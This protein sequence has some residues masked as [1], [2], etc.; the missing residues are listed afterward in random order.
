M[1]TKDTIEKVR[2]V[3]RVEEVVGDV[4]RLKRRG[5]NMMGLCPFHNEKTPSFVVSPAKGIYK[6]F[7]CG[8]S[9]D[10]I[11]FVI[12][13]EKLTYP[14]A[15]RFLANRY[16]IEIEEIKVSE[17]QK[18]EQSLRESLYIAL[19]F[20]QEWFAKQMWETED[21]KAIA[22]SY[23]KERGFIDETIRQFG[24]GYSATTSDGFLKDA[25]KQAFSRE[26]LKAAGLVGEKDG[27]WYDFFRERVMFPIHNVMG[28]VIGFGGRI[29]VSNPKVGK[30]VN[31]PETEVYNKSKSLYG[32]FQAK[33][34]IRRLDNALLVEGYTDV[35]SFHQAGI[36]NAVASSGTSLT[37]EQVK[38]IKRFTE[39]VTII[40]DGDAAG[41]KAAIRGL[42]I[43]L[44]EGLNV[45]VVLLPDGNDPDSYVRK[46]GAEV[47]ENYIR[48]NQKDFVLFKTQLMAEEAKNDPI[49]KA[50]LIKD[51]IH[52]ISLIPDQIKIS[53]YIQECSRLLDMP[54]NVL[55]RE[56]NQNRRA[57]L[58]SKQKDSK[59]KP[60]ELLPEEET[61]SESEIKQVPPLE[62]QERDILRILFQFGNKD[63]DEGMFVADFVLNEIGLTPFNNVLYQKG[64]EYFRKGIE[65]GLPREQLMDYLTL[66]EQELK[67]LA[68]DL[69]TSPYELSQNWYKKHNIIVKE[70]DIIYKNDVH[71]AVKRY[72]FSKVNDILK[73]LD[74]KIKEAQEQQDLDKALKFLKKKKDIQIQKRAL[75]AQIGTVI[76]GR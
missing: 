30:Y 65:E 24:L 23:F 46:M 7:G 12:D 2:D 57:W 34:E 6:C 43:V 3:A 33:N 50:A 72:L 17:E 15:I 68:I 45:K 73:Q 31:T 13:H 16:N 75:A 20:A 49:K 70:K 37:V 41:I 5:V 61:P 11:N 38:L 9:G 59:E 32:I 19:Q 14:E 69:L 58:K 51:I 1:I 56:Y 47:M 62:F 55:V 71:S 25:E 64:V 60:E 63:M 40:Y 48:D 52:T 66:D 29:M 26:V 22:Y 28:K 36:K 21:G 18:Q 42:D 74:E 53:V 54:E 4:V 39:N 67:G 8:K 35:I 76:N 27:R 44:E 10:A